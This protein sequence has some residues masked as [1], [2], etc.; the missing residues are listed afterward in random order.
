M[1]V[2]QDTS[3][4]SNVI[5]SHRNIKLDND[6]ISTFITA[7]SEKGLA[8]E[9]LDIYRKTLVFFKDH[10]AEPY[11]ITRDTIKKTVMQMKNEG[12][13][14]Q[15]INR[16]LSVAN[17]YVSYFGYGELQY[18][19]YEDVSS[20]VQP[21]LSRNEYLRLLSAAKIMG[22]KKQYL[23]IKTIALTG[24]NIKEL[25]SLTIK[26]V[27]KGI[28][29]NNVKISGCL[30]DE[31]VDYAKS[32]GIKE[33]LLFRNNSGKALSRST[34]TLSILALAKSARVDEAKCNPRC[35]RKLYQDTQNG[36]RENFELLVEQAHER[37]LEKE[38]DRI[39]WNDS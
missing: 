19:E 17:S 30:R 29:P 7:M 23:L 39:G 25:I 2:R 28:M 3:Y 27:E 4:D 12:Y 20:A 14:G 32:E 35:L 13:S 15:T 37:L 38:Q 33:G 26:D 5:S 31:L 36:I 34:I 1:Y 16:F 6:H 9:T 8:G 18:R 10:I 24:V 11:I 21:E 22:Q